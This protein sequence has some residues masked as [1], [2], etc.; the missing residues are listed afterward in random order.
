[1][2]KSKINSGKNP[3]VQDIHNAKEGRGFRRS[4]RCF[5]KEKDGF[6]ACKGRESLSGEKTQRC[7]DFFHGRRL[8]SL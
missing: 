4:D 7:D 3:G 8:M 2:D 5:D 1:M 6:H